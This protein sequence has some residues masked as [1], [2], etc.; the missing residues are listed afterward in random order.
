MHTLVI[1][2]DEPAIREGMLTLIDWEA[3]GFR[4]AGTAHNGEEGLRLHEQLAPDLMLIDIRMPRKSGLELLE[5]IR[6]SDSRCRILILSGHADFAYAQQAIRFGI[7]GYMLKPVDEQELED[8]ARR[9][10]ES[11]TAEKA[12]GSGGGQA[13]EEALAALLAGEEGAGGGS[14]EIATALHG[15]DRGPDRIDGCRILLAEPADYGAEP[16]GEAAFRQRL[17]EAAERSGLGLVFDAKPGIGWLLPE[18][19][20]AQDIGRGG[21]SDRGGDRE[22]SAG[23]GGGNRRAVLAG[24]AE[25]DRGADAGQSRAEQLLA[26]AAGGAELYTAAVGT[27]AADAEAVRASL[28]A[29]R[30]L[31]RHRFLLEPG[32]VH[33]APPVLL[34]SCAVEHAGCPDLPAGEEADRGA[35]AATEPDLADLAQRLSRVIDAGIA[36]GII[37]CFE[38]AVAEIA[39]FNSARAYVAS[40]VAQ[41]LT[42]VLAELDAL[43]ES[44]SAQEHN[45]LIA[46]AYAKPNFPA[47]MKEL[48]R[49]LLE[50]PQHLG[51]SGA[52][53]ILRR[54]TD[55]IE[56][57]YDEPLKLETLA[58]L[59]NYN[60]GYLGKLFKS[61]TG[62][63]FNTYLDRVRIARAIQLLSEGVKVRQAAEKVGYAN[64][65]YFHAKFKKYTGQSPSAYK[66][67]DGQNS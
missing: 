63:S 67:T 52:Q 8:Y 62:G 34:G 16:L 50:L 2:D 37:A 65:D 36:T 57:H 53:P 43:H 61:Y 30:E 13:R 5:D 38:A 15:P 58:E 17:A 25:A 48:R 54:M 11:L 24:K 31:M 41:L 7:E 27:L 47:L 12:A 1:V 29:A 66:K 55:Y 39:A 20:L 21:Q 26:E 22:S 14:G 56:R 3:I 4:V 40:S 42:Y 49:R 46:A 28:K 51:T 33:D 64:A 44:F 60:S 59:F 10:A 45:G 23:N 6:R 18:E 19:A 35:D 9:I 32:R